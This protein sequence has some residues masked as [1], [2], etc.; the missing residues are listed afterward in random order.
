V[1]LA[2][3]VTKLNKLYF[4][5]SL[6]KIIFSNVCS[7]WLQTVMASYVDFKVNEFFYDFISKKL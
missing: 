5:A 2:P 6:D 1:G 7:I 4:S 3:A